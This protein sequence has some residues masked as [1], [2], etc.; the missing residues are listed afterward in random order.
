MY[1]T[2]DSELESARSLFGE[3]MKELSFAVAKVDALTRQLEE[4]HNGN[5][6]NSYHVVS[7]SQTLNGG[8]RLK[9]EHEKLRKDVMTRRQ[10]ITDQS[11]ELD[12]KKSLLNQKK[13]ELNQLDQRIHELHDRL[14]KKKL[15]NQAQQ[16]QNALVIQRRQQQSNGHFI[17]N[18]LNNYSSLRSSLGRTMNG[19]LNYGN[20]KRPFIH[21]NN[22]NA[23]NF[24]S[25]G[26]LG[27]NIA[28]VEPMQRIVSSS[29]QSTPKNEYSVTKQVIT[30]DHHEDGVS[31]QDRVSSSRSTST[32][33]ES[34]STVNGLHHQ[35]QEM[36]G[37]HHHYETTASHVIK[38]TSSSTQII[39]NGN[40]R[41]S[42][43]VVDQMV[44]LSLDKED[45]S[46]LTLAGSTAPCIDWQKVR[47]RAVVVDDDME[48]ALSIPSSNSSASSSLTSSSSSS[49][50]SPDSSPERSESN[51]LLHKIV[52]P[53]SSA[54]SCSDIITGGDAARIS[55]PQVL[56]DHHHQSSTLVKETPSLSDP[57]SSVKEIRDET[58]K[59]SC[60]LSATS[61]QGK[62]FSQRQV[63]DEVC[64]EKLSSHDLMPPLLTQQDFHESSMSSGSDASPVKMTLQSKPESMK[65][66]EKMTP[67]KGGSIHSSLVTS[68]KQQNNNLLPNKTNCSQEVKSRRVSF[69]PLALLLDAALEGELDLVKKTALQVS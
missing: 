40:H 11:S 44:T 12:F 1:S 9:Q 28:A 66:E 17:S 37:H 59:E 16:Q 63:N 10:L 35:K 51:K 67:I 41:Q 34:S 56:Q 8:I 19:H 49:D 26:N 2:V 30:S 7:S 6:S 60:H 42:S 50:S 55:S 39:I 3:K 29:L 57:E 54:S 18:E 53:S 48:R 5:S 31:S 64:L 45:Q 15:L 33:L 23:S 69:D 68:L 65:D 43:D 25:V 22:V 14:A 52:H 32:S 20:I 47:R 38:E 58:C 13:S 61:G 4:L 62:D 27:V 46:L 36:T 24:R 21:P